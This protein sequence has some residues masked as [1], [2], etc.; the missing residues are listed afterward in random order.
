MEYLLRLLLNV[1]T[2]KRYQIIAQ[3][4]R[5]L[6]AVEYKERLG[7]LLQLDSIRTVEIDEGAR[8]FAPSDTTEVFV[9]EAVHSYI[10][11]LYRSCIF[12]C[13]TAAHHIMQETILQEQGYG[14]AKAKVLHE[15]GFKHL[16][17]EAKHVA[18]LTDCLEDARWLIRVRHK[19]AAHPHFVRSG[20]AK[21]Q[22]ELEYEIN[23]MV[24]GAEDLIA[25]LEPEAR[26]LVEAST[27]ED[28][29]E[30]VTFRKALDSHHRVGAEVIWHQLQ[31]YV[32]QVLAFEAYRRLYSII[33]KLELYPIT[34]YHSRA[35]Y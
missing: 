15:M 3:K 35:P 21:S 13:A 4:F 8:H 16:L 17:Q 30:R 32:I 28:E 9:R 5:E 11:G 31:H 1:A 22:A 23:T 18:K 26:K 12:C 34:K 10:D 19:V 33:K 29:K 24:E 7:R 25:L 14:T 2:E 27:V 20:R 6:E